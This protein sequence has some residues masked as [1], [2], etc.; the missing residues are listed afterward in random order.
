MSAG[1]FSTTD[2]SKFFTP[3]PVAVQQVIDALP[4]GCAR[5]PL[6]WNKDTNCLEVHW[7]HDKL[8]TPWTFPVPY[9]VDQMAKGVLP[10]KA[11]RRQSIA[12]PTPQPGEPADPTN[13]PA[14]IPP[15]KR[16]KSTPEP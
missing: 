10:E 4:A 14:G 3:I 8:V 7:E 2:V 1:S 15:R 6:V 13:K 5:G 16:K 12:V 9:T 11:W